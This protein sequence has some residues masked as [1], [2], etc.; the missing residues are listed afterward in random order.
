MIPPEWQK[1]RRSVMGEAGEEAVILEG[2]A[3]PDLTED[4]RA[5]ISFLAF[6]MYLRQGNTERTREV[7]Q[8]HLVFPPESRADFEIPNALWSKMNDPEAALAY[9]ATAKP[10]GLTLEALV[11]QWK[12]W[13][14]V[15]LLEREIQIAQGKAHEKDFEA[16]ADAY[17]HAIPR[18][19]ILERTLERSPEKL[20]KSERF[21]AAKWI[22]DKFRAAAS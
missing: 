10:E 15:L 9:I 2:F 18:A 1:R 14:S 16:V 19:V 8:N 5:Q 22:L 12:D 20:V 3:L 13:A 11:Q 21:R 7:A 4:E 6:L 17:I